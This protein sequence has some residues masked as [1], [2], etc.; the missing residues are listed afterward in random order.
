M[1]PLPVQENLSTGVEKAP[2]PQLKE[3][4]TPPVETAETAIKE[5]APETEPAASPQT[6]QDPAVEGVPGPN[7]VAQP[8]SAGEASPAPS[9]HQDVDQCDEIEASDGHQTAEVTVLN[10]PTQEEET[11]VPADKVQNQPEPASQAASS[12]TDDMSVEEICQ[13]MTLEEAGAIVVPSGPNAG[14]TMAQVAERRPS[15]LR[16]FVTEFYKCSNSHKAAAALLMQNLDQ[17]KAG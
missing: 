12:Y 10:F 4:E 14:L 9:E 17:K 7:P 2:V 8:V 3:A 11:S 13:V 6:V 5:P 16:F 1:E 15:S